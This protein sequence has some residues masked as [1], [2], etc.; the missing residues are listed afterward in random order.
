MHTTVRT[1]TGDGPVQLSEDE[2]ATLDQEKP[3]RRL[4]PWLDRILSAWCAV[5]S[6]GVLLQVF[7]PLSAGTQFYLVIFLT[8]ILPVTL[9]C[10][11]GRRVPARID[12]HR[13]NPPF[14]KTLRRRENDNPG[15][16]DW[17]SPARLR[18][19]PGAAAGADQP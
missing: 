3:A 17:I 4:Q 12:Q 7:V 18:R 2:L 5:V 11:R 16:P 19:I 10:Y 13:M 9:L 14:M 6:A 15:V 8:A 1:G